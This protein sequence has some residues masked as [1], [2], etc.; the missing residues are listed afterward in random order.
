MNYFSARLSR[1]F[2]VKIHGLSTL[3]YVD[4]VLVFLEDLDTVSAEFVSIRF[5]KHLEVVGF[6]WTLVL[7][8]TLL[9][10]TDINIRSR[11]EIM[12]YAGLNRLHY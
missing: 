6:D 3:E 4:F 1:W 9:D 10:G 12:V 8:L 7:N 2:S 5:G 11:T